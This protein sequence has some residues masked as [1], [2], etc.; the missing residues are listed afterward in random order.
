MSNKPKLHSN[1]APIIT[2]R[3]IL[4]V[5][6][7]PLRKQNGAP[8]KK[9]VLGNSEG[10]RDPQQRLSG[11]EFKIIGQSRNQHKVRLGDLSTTCQSVWPFYSTSISFA[12][13]ITETS[14]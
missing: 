1:T 10:G 12:P 8:L 9:D 5:I 3:P 14:A 6:P 11:G 2:A 4:A 13:K 7:V